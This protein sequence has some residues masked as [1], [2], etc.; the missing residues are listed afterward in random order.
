MFERLVL[1]TK[2]EIVGWANTRATE[3]VSKVAPN[4]DELIRIFESLTEK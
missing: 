3:A 2:I 4:P 1:L